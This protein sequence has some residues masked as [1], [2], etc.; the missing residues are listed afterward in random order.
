MHIAASVFTNDDKQGLH[1]DYEKWLEGLFPHA[2]ISQY[3]HNRTGQAC[4]GQAPIPRES[5]EQCRRAPEAARD[6][7]EG[8]DSGDQ[9]PPGRLDRA[10]AE[11][12]GT[13]ERSF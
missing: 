13:L 2:P 12:F 6:G 7:A 10:F 9:R 5:R 8:G 4:L 11:V 1:A 3:Q